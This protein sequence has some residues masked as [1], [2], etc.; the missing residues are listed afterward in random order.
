MKNLF[1]RFIVLIL[2]AIIVLQQVTAFQTV[3]SSTQMKQILESSMGENIIVVSD[4]DPLYSLLGSSMACY[5]TEHESIL[6]PFLIVHNDMFSLAQKRFIQNVTSSAP[7]I[8]SIGGIV[9]SSY[10]TTSFVGS[11]TDIAIELAD[12]Y[13]PQSASALIISFTAEESY[14]QALQI[15]PL[16][17]YLHIPILPYEGDSEILQGVLA[18][19]KVSTLYLV[20]DI[21]PSEFTGF[22][23]ITLDSSVKIQN[24]VLSTI[25]NRFGSLNYITL[26]NPS[27][28][29]QPIIDDHAI[30]T[31][32]YNVSNKQIIG[33]GAKIQLA[34]SDSIH[35]EF[36]LPSGII[37]ITCEASIV[38]SKGPMSFISECSPIISMTVTDPDGDVISYSKTPGYENGK[39]FAHSFIVEKPGTYS[40]DLNVFHGF[41]GGF[42]LYRGISMV[43]AQVKLLIQK[44]KQHTPHFPLITNLSLN[45]AYLTSA[46]GGIIL[47]D[48]S[49]QITTE[50]YASEAYGTSTGPW[51][52]EQLHEYNNEKVNT[53]IDSLLENLTLVEENNLSDSYF[54]GPAWLAILADTNMIPMYYYQPSQGNLVDKGLPSDNPYS[55]NHSLSV[56]RI[57]G[58]DSMDISVLIGRTLF[59]EQLCGAP[60]DDIEWFTSFSFIFGGGYGETGGIFH[61]I[62]YSTEITDYG[63][64]PI[65]YGDL[66]NSRQSAEKLGTYVSA[67]YIEYLGHGDWFWFTPSLYNMNLYGKSIDVAHAKDWVY[68]RPSVFL[69]SACLM[70]RVD[71]LYPFTSIALTMLHAGCNAFVGSTRETGQEAG[72]E[73]LENHLIIDD[74]SIGEALRGEKRVD[75]VPPTYYVRTL[76]ADP[77]FNPY[78]PNNGFSPQGRPTLID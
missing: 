41:Q 39:A 60:E 17:S 64:D 75:T 10:P 14:E 2:F 57:I 24:T 55:L 58:Y 8:I 78:E 26:T 31:Y 51:Y 9:N 4:R 18:R 21:S 67:N 33:A 23:C 20:G 72:L 28:V 61:Q 29:Q 76:Y 49:W 68:E 69:T 16:S 36:D 32:L 45:A 19:L 30:E 50:Q 6:H 77:A 65:V 38:S 5:Y 13:Y 1:F 62:P 59:Y 43:D 3:S 47:A 42:F 27:D 25:K 11:P 73:V 22:K 15:S 66:R 54:S 7:H 40:V 44:D 63:F 12:S 52:E 74:F 34:G 35:Q 53:T 70:G 46:H 71:G 37:H 48:E 56:G